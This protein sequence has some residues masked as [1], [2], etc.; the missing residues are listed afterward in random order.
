MDDNEIELLNMSLEEMLAIAN[1]EDDD[2]EDT[3]V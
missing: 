1:G 2:S 3:T